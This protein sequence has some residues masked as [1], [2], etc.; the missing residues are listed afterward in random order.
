MNFLKTVTFFTI[1]LVSLVGCGGN[2]DSEPSASTPS[3]PATPTELTKEIPLVV[4]SKTTTELTSNQQTVII[5]VKVV[6][7]GNAS[8]Y[9]EGDVK[10][11][12]PKAEVLAGRDIGSFASSSVKVENG[13]A[14]FSYSGPT[15]LSE[16]TATI[17][18]YFYHESN[19]SDLKQFSFTI[20]PD[21]NQIVLKEY[22]L[23]SDISTSDAVIGLET[24]KKVS[25]FIEEDNEAK[26]LVADAQID[27]LRVTTLNPNLAVLSSTEAETNAT[28]TL[29]SSDKNSFSIIAKSST[30]SGIVPLKVEASFTD[31]NNK[32]QILSKVYNLLIISGPPSAMSITYDG[33]AESPNAGFV[34]NWTLRVT[35]K[36]NNLVNT[37]PTVSMGLIVGFAQDSS[38]VGVYGVNK[39]LFKDNNSVKSGLMTKTDNTFTSPDGVFANVNAATDSL[40]VFGDG[41]T[42]DAS[43]KWDFTYASD[44]VLNLTDQYDGNDTASLGFAVGRNYRQIPNEGEAIANIY[45]ED[46][47]YTLG[48]TGVMGLEIA[49]DSYLIGKDLMAW[50]NLLGYDLET[51]KTVRTGEATKITIR[52]FGLEASPVSVS[53]GAVG[54][55]KRIPIFATKTGETY[56]NARFSYDVK[57]SDNLIINSYGDT[58]FL[59]DTNI[60]F[61]AFVDVNVSDLDG[62]GTGTIE[63]TNLKINPEF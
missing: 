46:N 24:G 23:T 33:T 21:P 6:E 32:T 54:E 59:L 50:V 57:V 36:Y 40:V 58:N 11:L 38:S 3:T 1:L 29:L 15:R 34:E 47:N 20:N 39:Y 5:D 43:G 42:Y 55:V 51:N 22:K 28:S 44:T 14:R 31:V 17:L 13:V 49:G 9:L 45:P 37:N 8:P 52:N 35:D 27:Y 7:S 53:R 16:N 18:F 19:P 26:T 12:Y 63:I 2:S 30:L 41:Y 61:S 60:S 4:L 10:I 25:F 56:Q 48:S 62:N